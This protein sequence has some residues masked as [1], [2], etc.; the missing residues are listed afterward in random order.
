MSHDFAI[1]FNPEDDECEGKEG[2]CVPVFA[3]KKVYLY[4][5]D[6]KNNICNLTSPL[7]QFLLVF[8]CAGFSNFVLNQGSVII[9][10][11]CDYLYEFHDQ[12]VVK[13]H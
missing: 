6:T 9:I 10:F 8:L 7:Y 12:S 1:N 2:L 3:K 4:A 13:I 5:D 11:M